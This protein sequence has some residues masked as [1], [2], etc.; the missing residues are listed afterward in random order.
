MGNACSCYEGDLGETGYGTGT[1]KR[2]GQTATA[3]KKRNLQQ[4][5]EM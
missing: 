1:I 5:K 3:L 2:N 4:Y